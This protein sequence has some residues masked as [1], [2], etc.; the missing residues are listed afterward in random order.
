MRREPSARGAKSS[1]AWNKRPRSR[2]A[3][4]HGLDSP[5]PSRVGCGPND[6]ADVATARKSDAVVATRHSMGQ[7][8]ACV[9]I[10][11]L[12]PR[13][14]NACLGPGGGTGFRRRCSAPP[15]CCNRRV[16]FARLPWPLRPIGSLEEQWHRPYRPYIGPGDGDRG[17][18]GRGGGDEANG[19]DSDGEIDDGARRIFLTLFRCVC[20]Q[21]KEEERS[22]T[23]DDPKAD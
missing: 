16:L 8:A 11:S 1:M 7:G 5:C 20:A 9:A 14:G 22:W 4:C 2:G 21:P 23:S 10:G 12:D 18:G 6:G 15:S 3:G 19:H 13:H 17:H